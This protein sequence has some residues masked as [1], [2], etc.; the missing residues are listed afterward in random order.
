MDLSI[1][2]VNRNT[3]KLLID[4]VGSVY[5]TVP[6]LSFEVF[7]VDNASSDA[8]VE[9]LKRAFP[10]VVCVENARNLG[11]ARANNLAL[12][13]ANGRYAVL[14][15]TDTVLTPGALEAI[16]KFMDS[17][18]RV[19]VCGGQL[20]NED[21]SLQNS[22]ASMPTLST[23]LLNKS[24][25][26]LLFPKKYPGKKSRFS[27]PTEVDSIIGACMAVSKK[28]ID[29]AGLLDEA[30]FFFFEE[31]DWCLAMKKAGFHV[32]FHPGARIYH[33]QGQTAKKNIAA[34]RV[35]YW[36]SRYIFFRKNYS[37]PANIVLYAGL[38][39]RLFVSILLQAPASLVSAKT[40]GKLK[41]NLRLLAWHMIGRP[42]QWGLTGLPD[43]AGP[44]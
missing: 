38:I 21:G 39:T 44:A 23:E 37:T 29:R 40:R 12:K 33:L 3:K 8:S 2:I 31:T 34:A 7:V 13:R 30:Y 42:G 19:G 26:K 10:G 18:E 6:P 15:N 22:I 1:I 36:R 35:E 20:L 25:L 17:N 11:F 16:V 5:R 32:F 28:A 24:L 27:K 9:A 43:A 41:V 14:L 4:C